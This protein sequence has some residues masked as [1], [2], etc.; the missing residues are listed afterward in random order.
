MVA[1]SYFLLLKEG[2]DVDPNGGTMM[3]P[4][5]MLK[6]I[7]TPDAFVVSG[8]FPTSYLIEY[9]ESAKVFALT[10]LDFF[11]E[12]SAA[13]SPIPICPAPPS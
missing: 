7:A 3:T 9:D 5:K 12:S 10:D 8:Y 1:V 4:N 13:P 6:A 11:D 2:L